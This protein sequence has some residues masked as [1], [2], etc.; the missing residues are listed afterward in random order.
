MRKPRVEDVQRA[1]RKTSKKVPRGADEGAP[2]IPPAPKRP[3]V[4]EATPLVPKKPRT[5]KGTSGPSGKSIVATMGGRGETSMTGSVVDLTVSPGFRPGGAEGE[6]EVQART[7]AAE[8]PSGLGPSRPSSSAQVPPGTRGRKL[9]EAEPLGGATAFGD[10]ATAISLFQDILLPADAAEMSECSLSEIADSMF[11][12]LTWVSR[13]TS[14]FYFYC[15]SDGFLMISSIA[16]R[17]RRVDNEG[18][19]GEAGPPVFV[20]G[21][22]GGQ[23]SGRKG[24]HG[25]ETSRGRSQTGAGSR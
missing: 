2:S 20:L 7:S 22:G 13:P 24:R 23:G 9:T 19:T 6:Q 1:V 15:S 11:P 17:P 4:G 21:E 18:D 25:E 12:A 10:P 3:C 16:A 8:E 14:L 5:D